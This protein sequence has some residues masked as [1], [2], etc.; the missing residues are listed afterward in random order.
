MPIGGEVSYRMDATRADGGLRINF[1]CT[2]DRGSTDRGG[3]V[4]QIA[5][6]VTGCNGSVCDRTRTLVLA[7]RPPQLL[8]KVSFSTSSK[9]RLTQL[10]D[11]VAGAVR[12]SVDGEQVRLREIEHKMINLQF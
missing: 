11:L 3:H 12:R 9:Q 4:L 7:K 10:A 1:S 6:I 8:G 2:R 5:S